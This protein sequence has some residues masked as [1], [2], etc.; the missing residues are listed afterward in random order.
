MPAKKESASPKH[1]PS[2]HAGI[3]VAD[4]A[5][6]TAS[7]ELGGAAP[8][9][10]AQLLDHYGEAGW[11]ASHHGGLGFVDRWTVPV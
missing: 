7:L 4:Q 10:V 3:W 6:G 5:E 9:E 11:I 1:Q 2:A 8:E